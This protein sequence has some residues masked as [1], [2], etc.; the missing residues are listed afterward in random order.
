LLFQCK[1]Q[2]FDKTRLSSRAGWRLRLA[3]LGQST[4]CSRNFGGQRV[5]RV[6]QGL[7]LH[8]GSPLPRDND[9][10]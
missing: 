10:W 6:G 2:P 1:Q 8:A 9:S 5:A 7:P 4:Q 3:R